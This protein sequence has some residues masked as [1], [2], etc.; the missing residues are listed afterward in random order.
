[1]ISA[2]VL[3]VEVAGGFIGE[4]DMPGS[5]IRARAMATRC[6]SPP[7]NSVG[8]CCWRSPRPTRSSSSVARSACVAGGAVNAGRNQN[9]FHSGQFRHQRI[10][11]KYV[12]HLPIADVSPAVPNSGCRANGGHQCRLLPCSASSRPA[13]CVEQRSFSGAPDAPAEKQVVLTA[14]SPACSLLSGPRWGD[15]QFRK[16]APHFRL[17]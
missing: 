7:D 5:L 4:E 8:R 2:P 9:I 11:L 15:L 1:M 12:T 10:V 13:T 17:G 16:C 14:S 6:C 3:R